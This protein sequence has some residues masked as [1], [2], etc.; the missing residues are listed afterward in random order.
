MQ[1]FKLD[2]RIVIY[3]AVCFGLLLDVLIMLPYQFKKAATFFSNAKTLQ[4][5]LSQFKKD[6]QAKDT[7]LDEKERTTT[8][9]ANLENRFT[10]PDDM[11][12]VS[13]YISKAAKASGVDIQSITP[14]EL[15][16]IKT[17]PYGKVSTF[18]IKIE[19][20]MSFHNFGR[21]VNRL[22]RNQYFL[23]IRDFNMKSSGAYHPTTVVVVTLVRE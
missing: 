6:R 20:R 19:A 15:E 5:N 8:T 4:A 14:Q 1:K 3:G 16:Q 17:T 21:F 13:A 18:P 12:S 9:I 11:S 7:L 23:E 2:K 22:I 10:K